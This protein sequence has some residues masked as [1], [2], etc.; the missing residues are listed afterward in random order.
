MRAAVLGMGELRAQ[1]MPHQTGEVDVNNWPDSLNDNHGKDG[2][3]F[4]FCDGHAEWVPQKKFMEVWN[5]GQDSAR[6]PGQP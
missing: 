4:T 1:R 3:N 5:V 2:Q 6:L